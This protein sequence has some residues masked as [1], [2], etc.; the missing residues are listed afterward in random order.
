ML[1]HTFADA[2][3]GKKVEIPAND[4]VRILRRFITFRVSSIF[5]T[6]AKQAVGA[7]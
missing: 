4:P 1:L 6:T 5:F 3:N 7:C 2:I